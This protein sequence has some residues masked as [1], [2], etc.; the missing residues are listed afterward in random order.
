MPFCAYWK[1]SLPTGH[2]VVYIHQIFF[3]ILF[4]YVPGYRKRTR[5]LRQFPVYPAPAW[6]VSLQGPRPLQPRCCRMGFLNTAGPLGHWR[7]PG[8]WEENGNREEIGGEGEQRQLSML[9]P[10]A[11]LLPQ[12]MANSHLRFAVPLLMI[13]C[14]SLMNKVFICVKG[15][16]PQERREI[17]VVTCS[18][19]HPLSI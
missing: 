1:S 15:T 6:S 4:C 7:T 8:R 12:P 9:L 19:T 13:F 3:Q 14:P 16:Y 5:K 2:K 11:L 17:L 18:F 10:S